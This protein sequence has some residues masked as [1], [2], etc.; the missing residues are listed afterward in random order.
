MLAEKLPTIAG[1]FNGL[2]VKLNIT[3]ELQESENRAAVS[4]SIRNSK[5]ELLHKEEDVFVLSLGENENGEPTLKLA[6]KGKHLRGSLIGEDKFRSAETAIKGAEIAHSFEFMAS[7]IEEAAHRGICWQDSLELEREGF[8]PRSDENPHV[9][10]TLAALGVKMSEQVQASLL[11]LKTG[12]ML[13]LDA[14]YCVAVVLAA[15]KNG[16]EGHMGTDGYNIYTAK[17][18]MK[19]GLKGAAEQFHYKT[20]VLQLRDSYLGNWPYNS[21]FIGSDYFS[22]RLEHQD[23]IVPTLAI[24]EFKYPSMVPK[25]EK[26]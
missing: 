2:D 7:Y 11:A 4:V 5:N 25:P 19:E 17:T 16:M 23:N 21:M 10:S 6:E 9:F 18:G 15:T 3:A 8:V 24:Y 20:K 13:V 22:F 1:S 12:E 26:A 14:E